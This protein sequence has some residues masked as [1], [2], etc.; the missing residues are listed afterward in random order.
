MAEPGEFEL[1]ARLFAPLAKGQ[2]GALGLTD[3]VA[4]ID[5]A[6]GRRLA[7]TT[8]ALVAGVHFRPE[9]PPERIAR[10]AVRVNLSDLAAKGARPIGLL[11]AV[12]FPIGIGMG[13]IEAYAKGLAEDLERYGV[14]LLGGDTVVTPGPFT[15]TITALG[16]IEAGRE[17]L[18]SGARKGDRVWVSGTL[19]DAALGLMV[20][21]G[22]LADLDSA[23]KGHL[24]ERYQLPQPRLEMGRALAQ[25]LAHAAMD[26]SDGLI[27]DLGHICQTSRLGAVIERDLVPL[28]K[29]AKAALATDRRLIDQVLGGG[30]DY[31]LLFTADPDADP[32][33]RAL[34]V[35]LGLP[36]TAIGWM[37][38]GEGVRVVDAA[39]ESVAV[40]LTGYRHL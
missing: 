13:W 11:Q 35:R 21:K 30:D 7:I 4:L 26:I 18:R 10:K 36:L 27:G 2:P 8:D 28:G 20:L 14:P 12:A 19:G 17:L 16:E 3:D 25:G 1:I 38:E 32:A 15:V 37:V 34:S 29:A 40:T 31:E 22:G 24:V 9:D 5:P 39:G 6:P 23:L 33:L